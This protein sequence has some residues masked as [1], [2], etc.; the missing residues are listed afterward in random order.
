MKGFKKHLSILIIFALILPMSGYASNYLKK[1][2]ELDNELSIDNYMEAIELCKKAI[3]ENPESYEA[4]WKCARSYYWV[5][6]LSKK[7]NTKDWKN[8]CKEFGTIGMGYAQKAID[9]DPQ[10]PDGYFWYA[11]NAA[12]YSDGVSLFKAM[13]EGLKEKTQSSIEKV[14]EMDKMYKKGRVLLF[15]GRFWASLPWPAKDKKASLKYYREY[16][17]SA[18]FGEAPE[19]PIY[20]AELLID[21]GGK[22]NKKEA[23]FLLEN[24]VNT[25]I[26]YYLE[27]RN[28]V[29]EKLN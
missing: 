7:S 29:F 6:E 17:D 8:T 1:A 18:F 21:L 22:K 26:P 5:G 27:L 10:K 12:T 15:L 2:D 9:I 23:K 4:N 14:Y 20:M 25:Q 19:G 11:F 28:K 13:R 16:Q 24:H 3:M